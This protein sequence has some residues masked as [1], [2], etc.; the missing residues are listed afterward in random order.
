M[1]RLSKA[2][3]EAEAQDLADKQRRAIVDEYGQ[4]HAELSP[5]KGKLRRQDELAKVIRSW[6]ADAPAEAT[7]ESLG[8]EYRMVLGP[9]GMQTSLNMEEY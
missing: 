6:H 3:K 7:V 2:Q 9:R 5:I 4:L 8:D 1:P